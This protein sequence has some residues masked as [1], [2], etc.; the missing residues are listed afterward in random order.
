[1][2]CRQTFLYQ[3]LALVDAGGGTQTLGLTF[4]KI[5]RC[6]GLINIRSMVHVLLGGRTHRFILDFLVL[7]SY[8]G[9]QFMAVNGT[10]QNIVDERFSPS[11][12]AP[13]FVT[14]QV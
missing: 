1:M 2:S 13:I 7:I 6:G 4:S 3:I 10:L 8:C 14:D 5:R 11:F 9:V 12:I